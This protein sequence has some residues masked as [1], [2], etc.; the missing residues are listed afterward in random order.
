MSDIFWQVVHGFFAVLAW[1][2]LGVVVWQLVGF[3]RSVRQRA[4]TMHQIPCTQCQ[5]FTNHP[6][7]KCTI[8]PQTANT[9]TAIAC[10]DFC[11]LG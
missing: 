2:F 5:F 4:M 1:S 3:G 9:E 11:A 7:L 6:A 8:H 10:R